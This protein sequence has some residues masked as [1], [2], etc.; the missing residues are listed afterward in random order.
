MKNKL[1]RLEALEK[2]QNTIEYTVVKGLD[3]FYHPE[4]YQD[5]ETV[6]YW[7]NSKECM[8]LDDM[9]TTSKEV[10]DPKLVING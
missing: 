10:T 7:H 9:Y 1:K 4:K 6:K 3:A 2:K 8:Q 5:T